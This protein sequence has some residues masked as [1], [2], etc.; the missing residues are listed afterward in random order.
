MSH[1][2]TIEEFEMQAT[3]DV[4]HLLGDLKLLQLS[5]GPTG[6]LL[7]EDH[8]VRWYDNGIKAELNALQEAGVRGYLI[9]VDDDKQHDKF[10]LR[11]DGVRKC[12]SKLLWDDDP[13]YWV[14]PMAV[15]DEDIDSAERRLGLSPEVVDFV[16]KNMAELSHAVGD[17][18]M[19]T[20]YEI[21]V[22]EKIEELIWETELPEE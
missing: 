11:D 8:T 18:V 14:G 7:P 6:V 13:E 3:E 9:F 21:I 17:E 1:Y 16:R 20:Y 5:M 4:T 22:D 12:V 10:A 2:V 15:N 19:E